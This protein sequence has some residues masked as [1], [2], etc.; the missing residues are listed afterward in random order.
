MGKVKTFITAMSL[1]EKGET[2]EKDKLQP[3]IYHALGYSKLKYGETRFPI[4]PVINGYA[5][6]GDSIRVIVILT[7]NEHAKHN[8]DT[9]FVKEMN[10]L[11]EKNGYLFDEI[12][13][14][15]T[16][17]REDVNTQIK[18]FGDLVKMLKGGEKISACMTYGTKPGLIVQFAAINYAVRI[19]NKSPLDCIGCIAYGRYLHKEKIGR[20]YDQTSLFYMELMINR[21]AE[22]KVEDAE[23]VLRIFLE[24]GGEDNG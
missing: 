24:D 2:L 15:R 21:L 22:Q 9:Y 18:L 7:E 10:D 4:I 19:K 6:R 8:Y 3:V 23:N 14:V 17:D 5:D 12:E 13:I 1:Q 11:V 20:I 16:P